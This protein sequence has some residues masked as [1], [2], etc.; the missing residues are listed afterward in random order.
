MRK[1]KVVSKQTLLERASPHQTIDFFNSFRHAFIT[2][3]KGNCA[4]AHRM[5]GGDYDGDRVWLSWNQNLIGCLPA[6]DRFIEENTMDL[7]TRASD[8]ENKLFSEC[9]MNDVL[10]YMIHFRHHHRILGNLSECLDFYIDKY[11]FDNANTKDIGRAAFLQV[12]NKLFQLLISTFIF[13]N[14]KLNYFLNP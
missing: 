6:C 8:L 7:F 13:N 10:D 14:P 4:E 3:I 12:I 5:S 11:G 2:S 9:S 1:L